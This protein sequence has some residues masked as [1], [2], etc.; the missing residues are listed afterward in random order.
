VEYADLAAAILGEHPAEVD[1]V[2]GARSVGVSY[3]I[4][5]SGLAGRVVT[6]DEIL[7]EELDDYQK[8]INDSLDI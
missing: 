7:N 1:I 3:G 8:E 6:M 2:Q 5:E 4:L